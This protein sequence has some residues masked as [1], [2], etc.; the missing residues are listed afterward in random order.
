MFSRPCANVVV[1]G[2]PSGL[3]GGPAR[4]LDLTAVVSGHLVGRYVSWFEDDHRRASAQKWP[5]SRNYG[6]S[7]PPPLQ[8]SA[9]GDHLRT[10]PSVA[11]DAS[12]NGSGGP[13]GV[14]TH[15]HCDVAWVV[16]LGGPSVGPHFHVHI[17]GIEHWKA[18]DR[19]TPT[20]RAAKRGAESRCLTWEVSSGWYE[21]ILTEGPLSVT[22][23]LLTDPP[24]STASS[25]LKEDPRVTASP[26]PRPPHDTGSDPYPDTHISGVTSDAIAR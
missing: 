8:S 19:G 12:V 9:T 23:A 15:H 14:G 1:L 25:D 21:S 16:T 20:G 3:L 6:R 13:L 5:V 2:R 17:N 24:T 7:L 22:P 4:R 11:P 26:V 18:S 10:V